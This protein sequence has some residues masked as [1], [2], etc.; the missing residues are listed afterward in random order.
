METSLFYRFPAAGIDVPHGGKPDQ[1]LLVDKNPE[2]VTGRDQHVDAYVKFKAINEERL[3]E[4]RNR[5]TRG[6]KQRCQAGCSSAAGERP[7]PDFTVPLLWAETGIREGRGR[8]EDA[9][10]R[11]SLGGCILRQSH[12]LRDVLL[13]DHVLPML[14]VL[15]VMGDED[16][17]PLAAAVWLADERSLFPCASIGPEVSVAVQEGVAVTGCSPQPLNSGDSWVLKLRCCGLVQSQLPQQRDS[18]P[19]P[20]PQESVPT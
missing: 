10:C 19:I 11:K 12:Y 14:D 16:P 8:K 5:S 17:L 13:T 4:E 18:T 9:G 1:P 6:V 15:G 20:D 3:R 2:R 7:A